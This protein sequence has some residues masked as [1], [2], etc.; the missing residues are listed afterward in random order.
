MSEQPGTEAP[1]YLRPRGAF[2]RA[3]ALLLAVQAG[4][5]AAGAGVAYL[6][7]GPALAKDYFSA[8]GTVK[9]TWELLVPALAVGAAAGFLLGGVPGLLLLGRHSRRMRA[10]LGEVDGVLRRAGAGRLPAPPPEGVRRGGTAEEAAEALEPLRVHVHE[11]RR[12]AKE[13]QHP[14]LE[15]TYRAAGTADVSP[16]DLRQLA[17]ALDR[18]SRDLVQALDWFED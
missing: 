13:L 5:S 6:V 9:A 7:A 2:W 14:V 15:L 4:A 16:R 11:L 12:L 1:R 3:A 10:V 8:H 18:T 17:A